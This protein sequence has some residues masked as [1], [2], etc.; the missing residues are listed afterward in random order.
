MLSKG[1]KHNLKSLDKNKRK[2][3]HTMK[4]LTE[5][6]KAKI[7]QEM[8]AL[9]T[10]QLERLRH[11]LHTMKASRAG[12]APARDVL[13]SMTDLPAADIESFNDVFQAVAE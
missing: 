10:D 13:T 3:W 11:L 1:G 2:E 7:E 12:S 8:R 6:Q 5:A 9:P 4:S